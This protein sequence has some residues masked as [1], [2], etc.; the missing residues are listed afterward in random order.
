M[1]EVEGTIKYDQSDFQYTPPLPPR[2]YVTL[3]KYRKI[4]NRLDLIAAYPDGLGFGNISMRKNYLHFRNTRRPQFL[5]TGSQTGHLS[6]LDGRHY[7]MVVDFDIEAFSVSTRG[8]VNAS[9]ESVTHAAIYQINPSIGAVIHI[10]NRQIWD[11]MQERGY[12][13]TS[14]WIP[15]GTYEMAVAVKDCIADDTQ[16]IFVMKGHTEGVIAYGPNLSTAMGV[17]EKVYRRF[18]DSRSLTW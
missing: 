14:K 7:A 3:E 12:P 15:Y 6:D 5:I 17:I 16:G 11:G 4:L 2:E 18:V 1:S 8:A 9:S 13:F 10:H